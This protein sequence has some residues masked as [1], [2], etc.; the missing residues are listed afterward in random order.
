MSTSRYNQ[1]LCTSRHQLF[2][3]P[4][5]SGSCGSQCA[6]I[7]PRAGEATNHAK[8]VP[9]EWTAH[10]EA[11]GEV[12]LKATADHR[13]SLRAVCSINNGVLTLTPEGSTAVVAEVPVAELAVGLQRGRNNM[14]MIATV[15]QN[16]MF[17]EIF[18]FA[19]DQVKRNKW[20]AVFRRMGVPVSDLSTA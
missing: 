16:K 3:I 20:I 7:T 14:F 13:R 8:P 18:C 12:T 1:E 6:E 4:E 19:D 2:P 15:Y 5:A 11:R 17:D 10:R 9:N